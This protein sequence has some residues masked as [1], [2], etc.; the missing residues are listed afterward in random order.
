MPL[1]LSQPPLLQLAQL[2]PHQAPQTPRQPLHP[3]PRA[4]LHQ[5]PL[6]QQ[7]LCLPL[8]VVLLLHPT[9]LLM[10]Q[11]LP[12]VLMPPLQLHPTPL[13]HLTQLLLRAP[14]LH[15]RT[16]PLLV[17]TPPLPALLR[18]A[19]RLSPQLQVRG[20]APA[21]GA[22]LGCVTFLHVGM[23]EAARHQARHDRHSQQAT[24]SLL[25]R[26]AS[27]VFSSLAVRWCFTDCSIPSYLSW[28]LYSCLTCT[29]PAMLRCRCHGC[30]DRGSTKE[31]HS[32][33]QR[34][35]TSQRHSCWGQCNCCRCQ[36]NRCWCQR[37]HCNLCHACSG[38]C[39]KHH[40]C[41]LSSAGHTPRA[42]SWIAESCSSC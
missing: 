6:L 22:G 35:R 17:Q 40:S 2:L 18:A 24:C 10:P 26:R 20:A 42:Q 9:A 13:L 30:H 34:H 38:S 12:P 39:R 25:R 5:T 33:S 15:L 29:L 28:P 7:P 31:R 4:P 32:S 19:W 11:V 36:R 14:L 16:P 41:A 37:H 3:P 23:C 21:T 8:R 1:L 27:M